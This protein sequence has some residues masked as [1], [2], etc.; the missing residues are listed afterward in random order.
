MLDT[1]TQGDVLLDTPNFNAHTTAVDALWAGVP[2]ITTPTERLVG[3]VA[4]SILAAA[5]LQFLI[6]RNLQVEC[7]VV[8]FFLECYFGLDR[9]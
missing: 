5:G 1:N 3:R 6:A 7:V 8:A 2:L 9:V 4:S